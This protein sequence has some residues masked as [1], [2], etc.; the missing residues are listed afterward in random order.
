MS[1]ASTYP[2]TIGQYPGSATSVS[3]Y[4]YDYDI[5]MDELIIFDSAL[6]AANILKL[7]NES[8]GIITE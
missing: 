1:S 8:Q 7:W 6:S 5:V 4:T 2:V 3:T